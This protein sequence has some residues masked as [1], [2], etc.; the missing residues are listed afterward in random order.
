MARAV[1]GLSA[2]EGT[3]DVQGVMSQLSACP[4]LGLSKTLPLLMPL[5]YLTS[6]VLHLGFRNCRLETISGIC[7]WPGGQGAG[8]RVMGRL[9]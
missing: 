4:S 9:D 5:T 2:S 3:W 1:C 7:N 6:R 8:S